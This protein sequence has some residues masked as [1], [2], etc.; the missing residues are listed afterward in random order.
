MAT[1]PAPDL[2]LCKLYYFTTAMGLACL[3]PFLPLI[4]ERYGLSR[5]HIGLMGAIRPLLGTLANP[6]WSYVCDRTQRHNAIHFLCLVVQVVGY[7]NLQKVPRAF[8][9]LYAWVATTEAFAAC[10]G[11]LADAA[12][13]LMC[14]RWNAAN[15]VS[16]SDV[17]RAASYG[18]QR[19]WGAVSWGF[20]AAPA[21]GAVMSYSSEGVKRNAPFV[22]YFT[23]LMLGAIL[24]WFLQHD[25]VEAKTVNEV[26]V[27]KEGV[28]LA[29]LDG[30]KAMS[31]IASAEE[32]HA[33]S[34]PKSIHAQL[35]EVVGR[36]DIALRFFG[37]FVSGAS[38]AITDVFLFIWLQENGSNAAVM[39]VALFFTCITEVLIF[40]NSSWIRKKL[41]LDWSLILTPYCY[42]FRQFYYS[43]MFN[44]WKSAWWVLPV[45]LLHGIT[46][47]LYWS[48][49]NQFVQQIAPRGLTT[50]MMGIFSGVNNS[51]AFIGAVCGGMVYDKFGGDWLFRG[52]ALINLFM[53]VTFT[54][55]K[56]YVDKPRE[57]V[58]YVRLE[59]N[60]V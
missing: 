50:S 46:F 18:R 48:T 47:G 54:I 1:R 15:G 35:W 42:F 22:G 51:G 60:V 33:P 9:S 55:L 6:F 36:V 27:A 31:R 26:V 43:E 2:R 23:F 16:E 58:A 10:T 17:H 49:A 19:L 13:G 57:T 25:P 45:Q 40:Y 34:T 41:S 21:M 24:S 3:L 32:L 28:E 7:S 29:V 4:Y 12:V 59:N 37:F 39:G 14:K 56:V 5:A 44:I 53:G 20:I 30:E 8:A 52:I 38:M 11:T